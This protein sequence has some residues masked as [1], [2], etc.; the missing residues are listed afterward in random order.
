[1]RYE[2]NRMAARPPSDR[3]ANRRRHSF[4]GSAEGAAPSAST[5]SDGKRR[6]GNA[7]WTYVPYKTLYLCFIRAL[8]LA[9]QTQPLEKVI[10]PGVYKSDGLRAL[11][12][13]GPAEQATNAIM[14]TGKVPKVDFPFARVWVALLC[15]RG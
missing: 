10:K 9:E 6:R 14:W 11:R 5:G 4:G 7:A 12:R 13:L 8:I 3:R 2:A 1:M 15:L